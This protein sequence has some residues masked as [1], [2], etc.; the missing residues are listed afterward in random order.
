ML[1]VTFEFKKLPGNGLAAALSSFFTL[2]SM[3]ALRNAV[4]NGEISR[5]TSRNSWSVELVRSLGG[6]RDCKILA[7]DVPG[8]SDGVTK[9]GI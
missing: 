6:V 5:I 9:A 8:T 7:S 2:R 1:V 3:I 4:D